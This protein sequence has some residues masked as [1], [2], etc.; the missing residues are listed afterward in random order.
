MKINDL[1]YEKSDDD[2]LINQ[3][4]FNCSEFITESDG[5]PL[6][7]D[8]PKSYNDIQKVKVR[9]LNKENAFINSFNSVFHN[10]YRDMY[11]RSIFA[12]GDFSDIQNNI[13]E[14]SDIFYIFPKN[15]YQYM[16][17]HNIKDLGKEFK[18]SFDIQKANEV[19]KDL[20]KYTYQSDNLYEGLK[21]GSEI[22]IY[23][24]PYYYAVRCSFLENYN[25]L[26]EK[27]T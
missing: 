11:H 17:N 10:E 22:I 14:N 8:L 15:N 9:H 19:I 7:R 2:N 18:K 3:I 26:Y 25:D 21:S 5:Q 6:F 1:F 12:K 20:L 16:Y 27:I 24:I 4:K 13:T 23:G